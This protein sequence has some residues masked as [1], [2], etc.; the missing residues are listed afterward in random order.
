MSYDSAAT[1]EA[2]PKYENGPV[3]SAFTYRKEDRKLASDFDDDLDEADRQTDPQAV[4]DN[5]LPPPDDNDL[6]LLE[7]RLNSTN[8][9]DIDYEQYFD[10]LYKDGNLHQYDY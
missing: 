9:E 2:G 4:D 10:Y 3:M 7:S 6:L 5:G 1:A 8:L